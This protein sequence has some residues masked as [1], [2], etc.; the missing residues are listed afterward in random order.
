M[1]TIAEAISELLF[2]HDVVVVPGLGAFVVKPKPAQVNVVTNHFSSPDAEVVFDARKREKNGVIAQFVADKNDIP[3]DEAHKLLLMFVA[4]TIGSLKAGKPVV[5]KNIGTLSYDWAQ[6]IVLKQ[7]H[8]MNY[9]DDAFGLGDFVAA[10]VFH[11]ESREAIRERIAKEQKDK[12]TAVSVDAE[13]MKKAREEDHPGTGRRRMWLW[14]PLAVLLLA[15]LVLLLEYFNIIGGFRNKT[16][17]QSHPQ[18][19][20]TEWHGPFVLN[21]GYLEKEEENKSID[22]C[23]SMAY[24]IVEYQKYLRIQADSLR[25]AFVADSLKKAA[26]LDD[27]TDMIGNGSPQHAATAASE[28]EYLIIGG[29]YGNAKNAENYVNSLREQ[30][31]DR[32]F[33][34]KRGSYWDAV[35]GRYATMSAAKEALSAIH[36]NTDDKAW[37]LTLKQG[38]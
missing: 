23:D 14:I 4:D 35:F 34:N 21:P 9:N 11:G 28:T 3:L 1:I 22:P 10:S 17:P 32:A 19:P 25:Q 38:H 13:K 27:A 6:D 8:T 29:C 36:A 33:V 12:N 2:D 31:Y 16:Q 15:S 7:E 30:G 5:L 20:K 18:K 24:H 37:I 26:M